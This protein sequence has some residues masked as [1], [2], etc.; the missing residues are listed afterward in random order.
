MSNSLH[1]HYYPFKA[2]G[3]VCEL[4]L[5]IPA[6]INK[7]SLFLS[8]DQFIAQYQK[9]YTRYS[10]T[11]LTSEINRNAGTSNWTRVDDEA[12]GL[13]NYA[14]I[15]HEQSDGLF[16]ITSGVLRRAWNFSSNT[17][18]SQPELDALLPLIGW[19]KIEKKNHSIRLPVVGMEIDFGGYVKE[20]IADKLAAYIHSFGIDFGLVNLGGDI[21]IIGPH[22]DGSPW[23]VGIQHP[24]LPNK[25]VATVKL[26]RGG[27][28][29]SGD[30]ERY[31]LI[32]GVRYCHLLNP[33][34]G[35]SIQPTYSSI[36]VISDDCLI[37]GS[38]TSIALLKSETEPSWLKDAG[39][40]YLTVARDGELGGTLLCKT[41]PPLK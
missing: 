3:S 6:K 10:D 28:A 13:L 15:L 39:L 21:K 35:K 11:S 12:W 18:P 29:S 22:P 41:S 17:I 19:E 2:M 14:S 36:S 31:M 16:D 26:R 4:K 1:L 27:I 34:T 20:F 33:I 5:Y 37:A 9:K 32:D 24:R 8:V 30:Y 23:N 7:E 40:A 38:F 25:P